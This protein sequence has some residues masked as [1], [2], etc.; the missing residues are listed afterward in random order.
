MSQIEAKINRLFQS[1]TTFRHV[2]ESLESTET[3]ESMEA[4]DDLEVPE[5]EVRPRITTDEIE[6]LIGR[7]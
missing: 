3:E 6:S 5:N 1:L 2:I 7:T 4:S